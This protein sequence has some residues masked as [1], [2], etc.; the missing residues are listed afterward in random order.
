[1]RNMVVSVNASALCVGVG[2]FALGGLICCIY[3]VSIHD[4]VRENWHWFKYIVYCPQCQYIVNIKLYWFMYTQHNA[5]CQW[6]CTAVLECTVLHSIA[7]MCTWC[8]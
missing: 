4:R 6:Q 3:N 2:T 5:W 8:N 7:C 1:M